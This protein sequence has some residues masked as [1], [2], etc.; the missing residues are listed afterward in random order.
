MFSVTDAY[1]QE[2]DQSE[3]NVPKPME[4]LNP[5]WLT[6]KS[7]VPSVNLVQSQQ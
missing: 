2:E 5:G 1:L 7:E 6:K 4:V 3:A